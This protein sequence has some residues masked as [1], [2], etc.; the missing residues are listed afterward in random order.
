[1]RQVEQVGYFAAGNNNGASTA[2]QCGG[3][4]VMGVIALPADGKKQIPRR[5]G[6]GVDGLSRR[7]LPGRITRMQP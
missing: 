6:P 7:R 3:N 1:M 2:L 5:K 4:K